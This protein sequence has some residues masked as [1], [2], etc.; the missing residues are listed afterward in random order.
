M[1]L[2]KKR[3]P[4]EA[5]TIATMNHYSIQDCYSRMEEIL[6]G[7]LSSRGEP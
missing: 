2:I 4:Y 1:V 3:I 6:E 7:F 5:Q